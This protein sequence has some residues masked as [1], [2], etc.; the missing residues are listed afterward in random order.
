MISQ[1][2]DNQ[3]FQQQLSVMSNGRIQC[4]VCPHMCRLQPGQKGLCRVRIADQD[5]VHPIIEQIFAVWSTA[6]I[7]Q[8]SLFHFYPGL[9]VLSLGSVGCTANCQYC[10]NWELALSPRYVSQWSLP[11]QQI[12]SCDVVELAQRTGCKAIAFTYNEPIVWIEAILSIAQKARQNG[13]LVILVTNGFITSQ[14]LKLMT[15]YLSAVKLDLKASDEEQY[16]QIAGITQMPVLETLHQLHAAKVWLEV[17][18]VVVPGLIDSEAVISKMAKQIIDYSSKD[19]PWHLMRFFPSYMMTDQHIGSLKRL[20]ELRLHAIK[21][22]LS[23]VYIS[24]V[25]QISER[26]T[27][28]SSCQSTIAVRDGSQIIYLPNHCPRC[29]A[30]IAGCGLI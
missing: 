19:T 15:P 20:R 16:Q 27:Q 17:S 6:S 24:N 22:G 7:E 26:N 8:H 12:V 5:H 25:P 4:L 23:Y 3:K 10:Q 9:K 29:N 11:E 21:E 30:Q 14:A 2:S 18:T 1:P 28:C 13:L